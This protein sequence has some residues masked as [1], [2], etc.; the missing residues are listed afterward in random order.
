MDK[1]FV[2]THSSKQLL[3]MIKSEDTIIITGNAGMGK[4][5][6][7]RHIALQMKSDGY[8][9]LPI[10]DPKDILTYTLPN[11]KT[12]YVIDDICGK[13]NVVQNL[14]EVW[15]YNSSEIKKSI[16]KS[17]CKI[18]S[19]CRLQVFQSK[20]FQSLKILSQK[21][22]NMLTSE[23]S[24]TTEE[25][26][27]IAMK[28][29]RTE[30]A[31]KL[32]ADIIN[33][34]D[35]F[36]L[37]CTLLTN[38]D[39]EKAMLFL[40]RPYTIFSKELDLL[41]NK[42]D[43]LMYCALALVVAFNNSLCESVL[44]E[45]VEK[46]VIEVFEDIFEACG[47]SKS[48]SR[49]RVKENLDSLNSSY[50]LKHDK[51]YSFIHPKIYEM[52]AYY[53]SKK[54]LLLNCMLNHCSAAYLCERF[55]FLSIADANNEF[56]IEL[57]PSLETTFFD[58]LMKSANDENILDIFGCKLM[59]Y[60]EYRTS[61]ISYMK[62]MNNALKATLLRLSRN[63]L[64]IFH[65]MCKLGHTDVIKFCMDENIE[66]NSYQ[67]IG[68]TPLHTACKYEKEDVIDMLLKFGVNT[69]K[70]KSAGY[71]PLYEACKT[72][73][74]NVVKKLLM[75]G[76]DPSLCSDKRLIP[77]LI[78]TKKGH[79]G[80]V[81]LLCRYKADINQ[82]DENGMSALHLASMTHNVHLLQFLIREGANVDI[83]TNNEET[84]LYFA[85]ENA[86]ADLDIV[87]LLITDN[88][89]VFNISA[90]TG[91]SPISVLLTNGK[92][93][94]E[95]EI[96]NNIPNKMFLYSAL[97]TASDNNEVKL[98]DA[99]L[100]TNIDI[101]V[102]LP[103][104]NTALH[105]ATKNGH[106]TLVKLLL[107]HGAYINS[108][109]Q[110]GATPIQL[111]CLN[112]HEEIVSLL[113]SEGAKVNVSNINLFVL[114][115]LHI[116]CLLKNKDMASILINGNADLNETRMLTL[117]TMSELR[118][119]DYI[120][121]LF[122]NDD[123]E[124]NGMVTPIEIVCMARDAIVL[125]YLL[126]KGAD[127]NMKTVQYGIHPLLIACFY[128]ESDMIDLL[129]HHRS[130]VN[131]YENIDNLCLTHIMYHGDEDIIELIAYRRNENHHLL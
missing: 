36:P 18:L 7:M 105:I 49:Q 9:V 69:N 96:L 102:I 85:C 8:E 21:Q 56:Q 52:A 95:N 1:K 25:K 38:K 58:K 119:N 44:F 63:G 75:H 131:V 72:G 97:E 92:Q 23:Y 116:S 19:N 11:R 112:G 71:T 76:A 86:Y 45:N 117:Q 81:D 98:V 74:T 93:D 125:R 16:G 130:N 77:L 110:E 114:P 62:T 100:L 29:L 83:K 4:S 78:A 99:L 35:C 88:A 39:E 70:Y 89:D 32:P 47:E 43:R 115:P 118:E 121:S 87:T 101:N 127:S 90:R 129:L 31:K 51:M 13:Y 61:L 66:P 126:E 54:S 60:V 122:S 3:K 40:K 109:T 67:D 108:Q 42:A 91:L 111:A 68:L 57:P 94:L 123:M 5:F 46:N 26:R 41:Y 50:I 30:F 48:S 59:N 124:I 2:E 106:F 82:Q 84:P 103:S 79:T 24:L 65:L 20:Q 53:F 73:K 34:Y 33:Q 37:L 10:I 113:V 6:L 12:L 128:K 120:N 107:F 27:C 14:I 17:N 28:Y 104:R 64:T 80:I 15:E 22:F 55:I